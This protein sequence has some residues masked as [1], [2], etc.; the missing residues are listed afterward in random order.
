MTDHAIYMPSELGNPD[1]YD[2]YVTNVKHSSESKRVA[3]EVL[4]GD[5]VL[6]FKSENIPIEDDNIIKPCGHKEWQPVK[7]LGGYS[8]SPPNSDAYQLLGS[9]NIYEL[10]TLLLCLSKQNKLKQLA[11]QTKLTTVQ[12]RVICR[13][14]PKYKFLQN[15]SFLH[16]G[17]SDEMFTMVA[18]ALLDCSKLKTIDFGEN[19]ITGK[20]QQ[21]ILRLLTELSIERFALN[22]NFIGDECGQAILQ[23]G[24]SKCKHLKSLDIVHCGLSGDALIGIVRDMQNPSPI[25][26]LSLALNPIGPNGAKALALALMHPM[27]S[28]DSL[29]LYGCNMKDEGIRYISQA[30]RMPK[31]SLVR[32]AL[33]LNG[34]T[35]D[36]IGFVAQALRLNHALRDLYLAANAIGSQGAKELCKALVARHTPLRVLSLSSNAIGDAAAPSIVEG[37]Q[38]AGITYFTIYNNCITD[39]GAE[40]LTRGLETLRDPDGEFLVDYFYAFGNP[41]SALALSKISMLMGHKQR[42]NVSTMLHSLCRYGRLD[43]IKNMLKNS[44][45]KPL[46]VIV[47][48]DEKTP[49]EVAEQYGYDK[50]ASYL[51]QFS[52]D[53][54]SCY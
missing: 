41:M 31:S 34:I 18:Q 44:Q 36:G 35:D 22:G 23:T 6:V 43:L 14:L 52:K 5:A 49:C 38:F 29:L 26:W 2:V 50:V 39:K 11:F 47:N 27:T 25:K 3:G 9:F 54:L 45:C 4:T 42:S 33:S 51:R 46:V 21:L 30:L 10:T 19:K 7:I 37:L 20:S 24:F 53:H 8:L 32:V 15:V 17:I 28:I 1:Q 12:I 48:K 16:C 40:V 13:Y